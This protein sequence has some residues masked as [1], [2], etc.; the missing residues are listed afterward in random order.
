L[1]GKGIP[2]LPGFENFQ[3]STLLI[4]NELRIFSRRFSQMNRRFPLRGPAP[5]ILTEL[6][7]FDRLP[8]CGLK[9]N[10][11]CGNLRFICENLREILHNSLIIKQILFRK[12]S[13]SGN[14]DNSDNSDNSG[15][16]V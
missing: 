14:S 7:Q 8:S 6:K 5:G 9:P 16:V 3:E 4:I 13:N 15:I 12:F 2:E 1:V 11:L 10:A